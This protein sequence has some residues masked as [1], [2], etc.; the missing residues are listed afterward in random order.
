M[1]SSA[2]ILKRSYLVLSPF[3][4]MEMFD[5][6]SFIQNYW[7]NLYILFSISLPPPFGFSAA[8][9]SWCTAFQVSC[10]IGKFFFH[11]YFH[12]SVHLLSC[13]ATMCSLYGLISSLRLCSYST[14]NKLLTFLVAIEKLFLFSFT[15]FT[16]F[17]IAVTP[18]LFPPRLLDFQFFGRSLEFVI[19]RICFLNPLFPCFLMISQL[20]L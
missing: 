9:F 19:V 11:W 18:S 13:T 6:S 4:C 7:Y 15:L 20:L 5:I 3:L 17:S 1:L 14:F 12:T 16:S 10:D 8:I 2:T